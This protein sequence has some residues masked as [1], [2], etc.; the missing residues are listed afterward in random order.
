MVSR[1]Y[2][3]PRLTHTHINTTSLTYNYTHI[4]DRCGPQHSGIWV[5]FAGLR[6]FSTNKLCRNVHWK[7]AHPG[8]GTL[9]VLLQFDRWQQGDQR[10]RI[11]ECMLR[12][13]FKC[14]A[15]YAT[16]H[17]IQGLMTWTKWSFVTIACKQ[18]RNKQ[19][20]AYCP[21]WMNL[22][23]DIHR[24]R[25]RDRDLRQS[26]WPWFFSVNINRSVHRFSSTA[27]L[28]QT[29]TVCIP[30]TWLFSVTVNCSMHRFSSRAWGKTRR[31]VMGTILMNLS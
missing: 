13:R 24:D 15:I 27:I 26:P 8:A 25:D 28:S 1:E 4:S 23:L 7:I 9:Q 21:T 6:A 14:W 10:L 2:T 30:W 12:V 18:K 3:Q 29:T 11:C 17:M 20:L 22:Y 5:Y 16:L 19:M 31:G